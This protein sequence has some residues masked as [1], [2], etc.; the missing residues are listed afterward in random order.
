MLCGMNSFKKIFFF[1]KLGHTGHLVKTVGEN[2][3]RD[4][5]GFLLL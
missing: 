5:V 1:L 2:H 4:P 3:D